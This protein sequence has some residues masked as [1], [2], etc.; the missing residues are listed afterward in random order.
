MHYFIIILYGTFTLL[1]FFNKNNIIV[2]GCFAYFSICVL[3]GRDFRVL[4][5]NGNY[6]NQR[7]EYIL[8]RRCLMC[9]IL[10]KLALMLLFSCNTF[11]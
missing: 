2:L 8:T 5:Y 3:R 1:C 10:Q 9:I 4:Y 7:C 6:V 11:L